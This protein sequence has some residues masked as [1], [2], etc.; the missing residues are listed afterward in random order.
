METLVG[1][2]ALVVLAV[3]ASV[4]AVP[5]ALVVLAVAVAEVSPRS[6]LA[7]SASCGTIDVDRA[8]DSARSTSGCLV[9]STPQ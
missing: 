3:A 8:V 9:A 1:P 7:T 2:V 5:A 4:A 6:P